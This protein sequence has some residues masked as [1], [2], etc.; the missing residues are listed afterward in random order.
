MNNTTYQG[1][2]N[3][4]TWVVSLWLDNDEGSY[5]YVRELTDEATE[6]AK[7]EQYPEAKHILGDKLRA[8]LSESMPNLGGTLW[9]YLLNAA[10]SEVGWTEIAENLLVTQEATK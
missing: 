4:E 8:W 2:T 3:Y 7:E 5:N 1:W 9:T 10:F 6:E